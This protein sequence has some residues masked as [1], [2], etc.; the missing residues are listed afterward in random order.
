MTPPFTITAKTVQLIS[1]IE[2]LIGRVESFEHPKPQP[3]LRKSNRVKTL[4]G[5]LAIEGNSLDLEQ[6]T[7]ILDGKSVIA[8]KNDIQEV[9]NA[10]A[11]YQRLHTY[12]P[13]NQQHLLESHGLM[14]KQLIPEAGRWR[15]G[16]VGV[17]KGDV[18][19]HMAPP[20]DRVPY[21]MDELFKFLDSDVHGLIKGCVF[22]YEFEFIHPFQDGNGRIGRFWHSL[23]LYHYHEVFEYIPVESLIKAHQKQ[24]YQVLEQCDHAAE[25]TLFVEF[26]LEMIMKSLEDFMEVFRPKANTPDDRLTNARKHFANRAFSRKD[27]LDLYKSISTA[28]ASRD[29]KY[30][31]DKAW[32]AKSGEK[33]LT[34]YRFTP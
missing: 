29:L 27:Y 19:S 25:S 4:Q 6:V 30:G 2:R 17:M 26:S 31:V 9:L 12:Q 5:S 22:H 28:T 1:N 10:N 21:L 24:Y 13:A 20:A 18:I 7:A 3:Q 11:V 32:L 15:S 16:N 14:M 8:P 34:C 23:M 33:A